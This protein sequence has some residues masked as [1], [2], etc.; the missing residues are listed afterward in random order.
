MLA[1]YR[2]RRDWL[3]KALG[4]IPGFKCTEPEGAF[5]AFPDVRGCLGGDLKSSGDFADLLLKEAQTVVTDGAG[6]GTEGFV[7]ISYATSLDRLEEG[8]ERIRRIASRLAG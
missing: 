4:E 6:F 2:R 7:R 5:Y 3:M 8:V 1:E